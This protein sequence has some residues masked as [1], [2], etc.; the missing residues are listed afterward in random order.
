MEYL[1]LTQHISFL[2][3]STCEKVH[4]STLLF[5]TVTEAV[6]NS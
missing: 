2:L 1:Q 3:L 5:V 4:V 6:C